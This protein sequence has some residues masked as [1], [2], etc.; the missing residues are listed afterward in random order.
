MRERPAPLGFWPRVLRRLLGKEASAYA[1]LMVFSLGAITGSMYVLSTSQ[2]QASIRAAAVF[3][4]STFETT[5]SAD[6]SSDIGVRTSV[7]QF[8]DGVIAA[9]RSAVTNLAGSIRAV[10]SNIIAEA[11]KED[12]ARTAAQ[13][14]KG[15]VFGLSADTQLAAQAQA[16][17]ADTIKNIAAG[18]QSALQPTAVPGGGAGAI[19]TPAVV[20]TPGGLGT[21]TSPGGGAPAGAPGGVIA[22]P[23]PAPSGA[24]SAAGGTPPPPSGGTQ[25]TAVGPTP[26]GSPRGATPTSAPQATEATGAGNPAPSNQGAATPASQATPAAIPTTAPAPTSAPVPTSAAQATVPVSVPTAGATIPAGPT[27]IVAT[28]IPPT[29]TPILKPTATFVPTPAAT[30][31]PLPLILDLGLGQVGDHDVAAIFSGL[32]SLAVG[33]LVY[34]DLVFQNN[35]VVEYSYYIYTTS[36]STSPLWTDATRGMQMS[37]YFNDQLRYKGPVQV[38]EKNKIFMN[39]IKPT[40]EDHVHVELSLPVGD[41]NSW[42][43]QSFTVAF[44]IPIVLN[45]PSPF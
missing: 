38:S 5:A 42:Q 23:T 30:A 9:V 2:S 11:Q 7:V 29:S 19:G 24:A 44:E 12:A 8:Q 43:G 13:A 36:A 32:G 28:P 34:R 39:K 15:S 3:Q 14:A 27:A 1:A 16:L 35:G 6:F 41:D 21:G 10:S 22:T 26:E 18:L 45:E 33:D 17:G 37:V 31:T 25:P 4:G 40:H 20:V